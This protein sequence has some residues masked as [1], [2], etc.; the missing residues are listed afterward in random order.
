MSVP[1]KRDFEGARPAGERVAIAGVARSEGPWTPGK[2]SLQLHAE[3]ARAAL[4]DAGLA[5]G[6]VDGVLTAGCDDPT[7]CEDVAH[8]AVFCEYMGLSP[9]F[10][11]TVDL[12]TPVF[13]KMVE[14]A[15]LAINAGLCETVLMASA[16]APVS[17]GS[18]RGAVEKMTAFGHPEFELPYGVSIP[19]FY[20]M[21]AR[22]H[23]HDF[24]TT[25]EQLA[26]VAVAMRRHAARNPFARYRDEI[27]VADVIA[28]PMISDPLHRLDCCVTTDGGGALV[29][30]S[31]ER[32]RDLR[33]HPVVLL[34]SAQGFSHEHLIAAPSLTGFLERRARSEL[35]AA[36]GLAPQDLD[37]ALLYDNFTISVLVQLEDLGFCAPGESG[38]LVESGHIDLGGPLPVN[39]HGGLLS[40]SHPG[41]PGGIIHLIEAVL[42]LRGGAGA[43]QVSDARLALVHGIGGIMSNQAAAIL[44]RD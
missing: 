27:T 9:R 35:Y 13:V 26:R 34:A 6:E 29:V 7:Y 39:P 24:G 25:P 20:A 4:D 32:A 36:A 16:E 38:T 40:E 41:R 37:L 21:I 23:M 30:T 5:K 11:Y 2:T 28:S 31:L 22:R 10:T 15:A 17:R 33:Q 42:Q 14:I 18:R 8:S 43:R 3:L 1:G 19:A 12:G 44:A